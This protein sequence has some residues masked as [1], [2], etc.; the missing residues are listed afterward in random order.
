VL[1][2]NDTMRFLTIEQARQQLHDGEPRRLDDRGSP[3]HAPPE[4]HSLQFV[5]A[6]E[7]APRLH[8]LSQHIIAVLEYWDW[9]LLWVTLTGVWASSEN[10]HLYYRLRQSYGDLRHLEEA[11]GHLALRHEQVDVTTLLQVA[12][13]NGWD[14]HLLTSHDYGRA[15]VSHDGYGQI[16]I[17]KDANLEPLRQELAS[18]NISVKVVESPV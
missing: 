18:A 5:F 4:F 10:L 17:A 12:M 16:S 14:A 3:L 8:W 15:F 7:P 9:C 1:E 6:N 2:A 13:M 11:P